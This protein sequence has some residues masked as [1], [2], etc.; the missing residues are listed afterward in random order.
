M[1]QES[2]EV[3]NINTASVSVTPLTFNSFELYLA[4]AL[5]CPR[6]TGC[7]RTVRGDVND[8]NAKPVNRLPRIDNRYP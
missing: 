3:E 5:P 4:L 1:V 2:I 8:L 6:F 7:G